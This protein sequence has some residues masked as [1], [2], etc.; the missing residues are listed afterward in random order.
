MTEFFQDK[1]TI[2]NDIPEDGIN[3]RHFDR[4]VIEK[5]NISKGRLQNSDGTLEN[6]VKAITV[7]TKDVNRYK[8]PLEYAKLPQ[9]KKT[10]FFTAKINDFVV[11][12]EVDDV[13]SSAREF[14]LLQQKYKDNGFSITAVNSSILEMSVDNI[15]LIHA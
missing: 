4:F 11:L 6:E 2:Y 12:S 10:N 13:V 1:V 3:D 15:Q 14:S 9:D 7:T 5:C 8:S